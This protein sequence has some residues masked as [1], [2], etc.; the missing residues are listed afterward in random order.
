M[1]S[2]VETNNPVLVSAAGVW[3]DFGGA[4]VLKDAGIE[5]HA[6]EVHGILGE[7]GAGKSTLAKI[8]AGVH[9][10]RRG[11]IRVNGVEQSI[12]SPRAAIAHG[13]ALIHQEPLAFPDLTAAENV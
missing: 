4:D 10:P 6:G 7:N 13:I 11:A 1:T 8:I 9:T 3:K 5:L 2:T 12:P